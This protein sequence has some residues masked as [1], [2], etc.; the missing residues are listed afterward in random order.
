VRH[1]W[2]DLW[3][4][5][6]GPAVRAELAALEHHAETFRARDALQSRTAIVALSRP[7]GNGSAAAWTLK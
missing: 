5:R 6:D 3:V 7:V 1:A 2:T 4:L